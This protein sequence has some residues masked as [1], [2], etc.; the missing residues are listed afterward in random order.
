MRKAEKED[1]FKVARRFLC[2]SSVRYERIGNLSEKQP[3]ESPFVKGGLKKD[4]GHPS[5]I[6]TDR[7]T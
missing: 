1:A 2:Y 6:L 5:E 7:M 3:P 4:S